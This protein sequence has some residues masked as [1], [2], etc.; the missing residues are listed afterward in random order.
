[1]IFSQ[2]LGIADKVEE[3]FSKLY[4]NFNQRTLLNTSITTILVRTISEACYEG[5]QE[6]VARA[7]RNSSSR[8]YSGSSRDSGGGGRSYSSGGSSAGGSSGGG[9][10]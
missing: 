1:M 2:L 4:P 7:T 3:Q 9:F 6:G 5:V 8:D 10:R